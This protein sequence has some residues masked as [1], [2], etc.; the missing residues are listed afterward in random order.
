MD[1]REPAME[2]TRTSGA[3]GEQTNVICYKYLAICHVYMYIYYIRCFFYYQDVSIPKSF[4]V[5][6]MFSLYIADGQV[7][8][9]GGN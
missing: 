7:V 3:S 9:M 8:F 6:K 1:I 4:L 5:T 2:D